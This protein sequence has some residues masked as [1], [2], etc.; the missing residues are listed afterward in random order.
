MSDHSEF[1][2]SIGKVARRELAVHGIT[3]FSQLAELRERDLTAIH[4]IGPKA[5][6]ILRDELQSRG[7]AF[8]DG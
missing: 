1:P 3:R 5:V 8:L 6:R 2:A 7:L 4:E